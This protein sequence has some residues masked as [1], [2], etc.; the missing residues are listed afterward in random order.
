[1][2]PAG[3]HHVSRSQAVLSAPA[4]FVTTLQHR[5]KR[6]HG[7]TPTKDGPTMKNFLRAL[8]YVLPYRRRLLVSILCAFLAAILWGLN[9]TAIYPVLKLLTTGQTLQ[10][11]VSD[12]ISK[13]QL[14]VD[15]LQKDVDRLSDE[16][17]AAKKLPEGRQK[18]KRLRD[19]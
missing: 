17:D 14:E 18:E 8:R 7:C 11:W 4:H 5:Q 16:E 15:K 6:L 13:Q 19:S 1:M 12:A 10:V 3:V 9:F 2:P